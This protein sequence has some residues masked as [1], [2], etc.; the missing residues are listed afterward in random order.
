M[1]RLTIR[2]KS[3]ITRPFSVLP[4]NIYVPPRHQNSVSLPSLSAPVQTFH[5]PYVLSCRHKSVFVSKH[6]QSLNVTAE[7]IINQVKWN[8]ESSPKFRT[9]NNHVIL[10]ECPFCSKPTKGKAENKFKLYIQLGGGAYF[11]HRCGHGGSWFDFKAKTSKDP[12]VVKSASQTIYSPKMHSSQ[13]LPMP[14][15]R[16]QALYNSQLL[17]QPDNTVLQYLTETRGLTVKTLRKYG[18]GRAKYSFNNDGAWEP[19]ECVTFPWIMKAS[20][21]SFQEELRG[22]KNPEEDP[23]AFL[24]RRIKVR[25]LENKA[26]QRLDPAGGGWGFFGYHTLDGTDKSQPIVLTEGEYDA[27]AV[28]QATGIPA[29]SLPNGCRSLPVEVLPLL[30]D[31]EKIYLWMDNDGAGQEG[32]RV[33]S[34]KIGLGRCFMVQPTLENT[35]CLDFADLPKD[36]NDALLQRHDLK[37]IIMEAK[38]VPH[39]QIL[40]FSDLQDSVLHE[41]L[42]PE[43]Y[44]GT[45]LASLPKFSA[46][47]KGLR[48]GTNLRHSFSKDSFS[49]YLLTNRQCLLV[50][51]G[52]LTVVTGTK[53]TSLAHSFHLFLTFFK[54]QVLLARVKQ[55]F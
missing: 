10:E 53:H 51:S 20:D 11:C 26:W 32:A 43:K 5:S 48:R 13:P 22:V 41:I 38:P 9:T 55:H 2:R 28:W 35:G 8:V 18:I 1:L 50:F 49:L 37:R 27:M 30:E 33:F 23:D 42:H 12:Q 7:D 47:V 34:Q 52:E 44:E 16:L 17:D 21:I 46:V 54:N 6:N 4:V 31:Y 19:V 3:T 36:A 39:E 15:S 45:K 14:S 29:I 40:S 24:T 25:A